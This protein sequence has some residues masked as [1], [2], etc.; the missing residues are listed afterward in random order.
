MNQARFD[1]L[2]VGETMVLVAPDDHGSLEIDA[3]VLLGAGAA[4][5]NVAIGAAD[6][7]ESS[8]EASI[9]V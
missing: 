7:F 5:S 9:D 2:T 3:R 4:E 8:L 1:L 6:A